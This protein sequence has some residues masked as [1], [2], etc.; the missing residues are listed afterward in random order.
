MC[1]PW[2][3]RRGN[4][5]RRG[6]FG[7]ERHRVRPCPV[8]RLCV[9][10][11]CDHQFR[12]RYPE[13][14]PVDDRRGWRVRIHR[15]GYAGFSSGWLRFKL[16]SPLI[17]LL[18]PACIAS[19]NIENDSPTTPY[20]V[21]FSGTREPPD[22]MLEVSPGVLTHSIMSGQNLTIVGYHRSEERWVR[23]A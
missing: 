18:P 10:G 6:P 1:G 16:P 20:A 4:C 7:G 14:Q 21:N 12:F 8:G 9:K 22:Q 11:F 5:Q 23:R 13:Y 2:I 17:L 3:Q 15:G 19:V